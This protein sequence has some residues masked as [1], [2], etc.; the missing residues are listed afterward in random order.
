MREA[1]CRSS[2]DTEE[3]RDG[4]LPA[5]GL[6]LHYEVRGTGPPVLCV[7]GA[8][9]TGSYEWSKVA[10]ALKDR[11]RFIIPDLRGH[12]TSDYRAGRDEHRSRQRE[13]CWRSSPMNTWS[14]PH[15]LA[16]SFGAEA[17]L[18]IGAA[19][20]G[21]RRQPDP[22]EPWARRP[23]S[24]VPTRA[25]LGVA[26]AGHAA[27]LHAERHG[28]DHWLDVMLELCDR[29]AKRPKADLDA[30]GGSA[31]RCFSYWA[32]R[33][34]P[35]ALRQAEVMRDAHDRTEI[36]VI[37]GG[38]HAVHKDHRSEVVA[39]MDAFLARV[40]RDAPSARRTLTAGMD[41]TSQCSTVGSEIRYPL[42]KYHDWRKFV[43]GASGGCR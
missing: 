13:T 42:E 34:T 39:A 29:A 12:G 33:T 25:Q 43:V 11:Y 23:K 2:P 22:G 8:T 18:D 32:A 27:D 40:M 38:R 19:L 15:V 21:H 35:V 1:G 36:V 9:G 24:S 17:A 20:S 30:I 5:D 16:F 10:D 3:R 26:L 7:H 14:H 4:D 41:G 31:V 6:E 28:Q 37:E